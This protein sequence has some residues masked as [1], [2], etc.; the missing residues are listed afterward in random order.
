MSAQVQHQHIHKLD[1]R[2]ASLLHSADVDAKH[3]DK[4]AEKKYVKLQTFAYL[5]DERKEVRA[6]LVKIL[7]LDPDGNDDDMLNL[8][9]LLTVWKQA[10]TRAEAEDKNN[11]ERAVQHLPPRLLPGDLIQA[12][13]AYERAHGNRETLRSM[14]PSQQLFEKKLQ[15]VE[16]SFVAHRLSE[17]TNLIQEQAHELA[18]KSAD[19]P[20]G[21][22]VVTSTFKSKVTTFSIPPPSNSEDLRARL[23]VL[24]MATCYQQMHFGTNPRL[25]GIDMNFFGE[26]GDWLCGPDIWGYATLD[27]N[28]HPIS[29]PTLEM[30]L[31]LDQ[32]VREHAALLMNN[33]ENIKDAYDKA[34]KDEILLKRYFYHHVSIEVNSPGCRACTAPGLAAAHA[35]VKRKSPGADPSHRAPAIPTFTGGADH[36][37]LKKLKEQAAARAEKNKVRKAKA[38]AK[39][40]AKAQLA[41]QAPPAYP[42]LTNGGAGDGPNRQPKGKGGKGKGKG[43][44]LCFQYDQ[45][46]PC[47]FNPCPY[48]HACSKCGGP[49]PKT[50]CP[51]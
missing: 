39:K 11:A 6:S 26:Y 28:E 23:K 8:S 46:K 10:N 20:L 15:E 7:G 24:G 1:P 13:Q 12:K 17:V 4:L 38:K 5:G 18:N 42:A 50:E 34:K 40:A 32:K 25:T 33:G 51:N 31:R 47:K 41:I 30:V 45:G 9:Q 48:T 27:E 19:K 44:G 21:F 29:T 2:L 35:G 14:V 22:D 3:M 49:H 43:K 16:T 37:E 36:P